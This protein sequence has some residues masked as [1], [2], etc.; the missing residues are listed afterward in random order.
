MSKVE[1]EDDKEFESFVDEEPIAS[2]SINKYDPYQLKAGLDELIIELLDERKWE[3]DHSAIN[4]KI[5]VTAVAC[6]ITAFQ[7]LYKP[8]KSWEF[9]N[10][11]GKEAICISSYLI[12]MGIYY[13]IDTYYL[14]D[15]FYVSSKHQ[16]KKVK[17]YDRIVFQSK[18]EEGRD[19]YEFVIKT[20]HTTRKQITLNQNIK[21]GSVYDVKGYLH[22]YLVK[23]QLEKCL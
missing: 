7:Q 22:R 8:D 18:I 14:G 10:A 16:L 19:D 2:L 1:K 20:E 9:P 6:A 15:T 13:Y 3:E 4:Y 12:L 23:E 5:F 21:I 17:N 11:N